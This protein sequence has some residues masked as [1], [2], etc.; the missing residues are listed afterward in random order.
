[1]GITLVALADAITYGWVNAEVMGTQSFQSTE[2][3]INVAG[4]VV[5]D[6][7]EL[8]AFPVGKEKGICNS[9]EECAIPLY[10]C[11]FIRIRRH[12]PFSDF[13]VVILKH[14]EVVTFQLHLRYW[15]YIRVL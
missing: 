9:F 1:M 3:T 5:S 2:T 7:L 6:P 4:I 14:L 11:L 15:S 13:E 8:F 12:L 10:E